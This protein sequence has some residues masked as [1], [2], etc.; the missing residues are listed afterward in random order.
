MDLPA[1]QLCAGAHAVRSVV[2][3][4]YRN[5]ALEADEVVAMRELTSLCDELTALGAPGA[6]A[7]LTLTVAGVGRFLGALEDFIAS[8]TAED[9]IAREGDA[10]ALPHVFAMV[11][12]VADVHAEALRTALDDTVT[13]TR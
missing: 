6:I 10:G 7:R 8:T 5:R 1:D 3:E 4:R 12:G 13:A 9:A 2:G 11:D